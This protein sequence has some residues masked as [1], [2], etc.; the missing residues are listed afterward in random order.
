MKK[1]IV[2][3]KYLIKKKL[4]S[5]VGLC[6]GCFD[7]LHAG[8][9][10]HF[11]YAKKFVKTLIVAI[12]S[13][14]HF[15]NKG[16]NRPVMDEKKRLRNLSLLNNID[17]TLVYKG[18]VLNLNKKSSYGYIHKKKK[19]TP[20]IPLDLFKNLKI[21]FYFKGFE[22]KNKSIPE[23]KFLKQNNIKIKYGPKKNIF[24]SSKILVNE[25]KK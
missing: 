18:Q 12:N 23:I 16:R 3:L 13:D 20:Y 21:D 24:S 22:Y 6:W 19:L 15:P 2:T 25:N 8:H 9:I 5:P 14:K 17:F 10:E 11:L 7:L 1:K 4:K